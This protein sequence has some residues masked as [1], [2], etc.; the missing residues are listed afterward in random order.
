MPP[1]KGIRGERKTSPAN[2]IK[3]QDEGQKQKK[4]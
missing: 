1:D 3:R 4:K 2:R